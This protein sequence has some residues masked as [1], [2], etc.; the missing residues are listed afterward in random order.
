M[1]RVSLVCTVHGETGHT[2]VS[3]LRAI[4]ER[5]QPDVIF[6][7]VQSLGPAPLQRP[8]RRRQT[9]AQVSDSDD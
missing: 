4:L 3:E 5:I 9:A 8:G 6:L 1:A 7:E 2:N